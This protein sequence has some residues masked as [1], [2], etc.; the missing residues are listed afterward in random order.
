[1]KK[2]HLLIVAIT[3]AL[4]SMAFSTTSFADPKVTVENE[5]VDWRVLSVS[6][7]N[8]KKTLRAI[9]GNDI[10]I[11]ASRANKTK[12]W[13]E[14]SIIAKVVWKERTHPNWGAAIVPGAFSTAEAMI[15]DSK[16]YASTGGW[17]YGHWVNGTL[18]MHPE[19][20]AKTCYGCHQPMKD[21]DYVYT[22]SAPMT[23]K[24]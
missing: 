17:G 12:P 15:K 16:K 23:A 5:Y 14:G 6:H 18:E 10:A 21:N 24:K 20:K 7:R 13:P 9:L 22:F 1:M 3:T 2:N 8:D 4:S 19:A 11:K